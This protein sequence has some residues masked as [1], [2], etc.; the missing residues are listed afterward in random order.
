MLLLFYRKFHP[1][2]SEGISVGFEPSREK[3]EGMMENIY[4][5][6]EFSIPDSED[7]SNSMHISPDSPI[8]RQTS[9]QGNDTGS[10]FEHYF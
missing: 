3:K 2:V 8:N 1:W 4:D 7:D 5:D 6:C 10:G 9:N